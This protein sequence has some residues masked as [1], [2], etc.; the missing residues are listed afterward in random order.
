[1]TTGSTSRAPGFLPAFVALNTMAGTSLGLAKVTTSFYALHLKPTPLELSLIAGAESVGVVAM[2]L[3]LG[4]LLDQFGPLRLFVTGSILAGSFF[5]LAPV[6]NHALVLALLLALISCSLPGR[7][8]SINAVFL[9]QLSRVGEAKA[10]WLRGSHMIGFFLAGPSLAVPLIAAL[11]FGGAY[12]VIGLSFFASTA[13][14]PLVMRHYDRAQGARRTLSL[15]ELG[16]QARL[17]A[18]DAEL[19]GLGVVEFCCQAVNQFYIFF[20]VVLAMTVFGFSK[21][22]AAGLVTAHGA[23]Y[24][25]ALFLLGRLLARLGKR[26]FYVLGALGVA[27][28]L[29]VLGLARHPYTLWA[30]GPLLGLSLGMMQTVNLSRFAAVGARLGRGEVAGFLAFAAPLGGLAGSLVGGFVA[31]HLGLQTVFLLFGPVFLAFSARQA[32]RGPSRLPSPAALSAAE[33]AEIPK[34]RKP[35]ESRA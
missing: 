28:A 30:G 35:V 13:L 34:T 32:L 1:M 14:A 2:S 26:R 17:W 8:V 16:R 33:I 23:A 29:L 25:L 10:G 6:A 9:Q 3:P 27:M 5:L 31:K 24:V 15:A 19:R 11:R 7:F 20:I 21:T 22:A 18:G 4:V 12:A